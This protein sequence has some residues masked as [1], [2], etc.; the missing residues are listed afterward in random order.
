MNFHQPSS[1]DFG[2]GSL[3][4]SLPTM[5]EKKPLAWLCVL[6]SDALYSRWH[7]GGGHG[8]RKL[9][10]DQVGLRDKLTMEPCAGS[11]FSGRTYK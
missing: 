1:E 2:I 8:A 11:G 9:L 3:P 5:S 6:S 10:V 4:G 7:D